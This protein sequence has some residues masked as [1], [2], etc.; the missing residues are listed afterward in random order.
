M[1]SLTT[2]N[3]LVALRLKT[4]TTFAGAL[5]TLSMMRWSPEGRSNSTILYKSLLS[6]DSNETLHN[7]HSKAFQKN[8]YTRSPEYTNFFESSHSFRHSMWI[9]FIVPEQLQGQIK[10]F[11]SL[12]VSSSPKQILQTYYSFVEPFCESLSP[13]SFFLFARFCFFS[14]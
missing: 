6:L 9:Y 4:C 12:S 10:M 13:L 2:L 7:S 5:C 3:S 11:S 8:D 14:E 1:K